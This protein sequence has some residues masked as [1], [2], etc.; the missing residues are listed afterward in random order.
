[1]VNHELVIITNH[2]PSTIKSP[3]VNHYSEITINYLPITSSLTH[4][5]D[6]ASASPST[7]Q[8]LTPCH[9]PRSTNHPEFTMDLHRHPRWTLSSSISTSRCAFHSKAAVTWRVSL[10]P[11]AGLGG[12]GDWMNQWMGVQLWDCSSAIKQAIKEA[13][14]VVNQIACL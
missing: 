10:R 8:G 6:S 2:Q 13:K 9:F 14:M 4:H 11:N 3:L 7:H 12:Q 1:M 5:I